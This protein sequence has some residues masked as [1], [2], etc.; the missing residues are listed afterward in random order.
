MK[1]F[2]LAG[3]WAIYEVGAGS[4][5]KPENMVYLKA[6]I[7][8]RLGGYRGQPLYQRGR[9]GPCK[10]ISGLGIEFYGHADFLWLEIGF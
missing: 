7:T 3:F 6:A 8:L 9:K 2:V 5:Q 4:G 10:A 1:K